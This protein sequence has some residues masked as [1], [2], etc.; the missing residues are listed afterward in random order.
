MAKMVSVWLRYGAQVVAS[1]IHL[2]V[3]VKVFFRYD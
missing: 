1:N 3:A 2:D